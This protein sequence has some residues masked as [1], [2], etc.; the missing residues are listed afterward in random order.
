[1]KKYLLLILVFFSF[2]SFGQQNIN[3]RIDSILA[4]QVSTKLDPG[5]TVGV[6]KGGKLIY[7]N[8]NGLMNLEYDIPFNDSTVFGIAS[9]TKQFTSAC[10]AILEKK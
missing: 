7:H 8:S 3:E 5:L 10:I 9:I 2:Y 1:M 4:E 6:V